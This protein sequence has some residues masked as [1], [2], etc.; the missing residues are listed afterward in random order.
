[1]PRP[2]P[3]PVDYLPRLLSKWGHC[4]RREAE[5]LVV[6]G[7]VTVNGVVKRRVLDE[8]HPSRDKIEV[9]GRRIGP[10]AYLYLKMHKPI[11]VVTTMKDPEGRPTIRDLLPPELAGAM[12]VGRLDQDS[13]GLLLL[14][15]D[16]A[17]G[18]R[19]TGP[20]H[21]VKKVYVVEVDGRPDDEAFAPIRAGL[22]LDGERCRP[23]EV[24]VLERRASSTV[25]QFVLDEGKNRQIRRSLEAIG[26]RVIALHRTRIGPIEL[27]NLAEGTVAPLASEELAALRAA[28]GRSAPRA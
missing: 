10:A 8:V 26:L 27:G 12:P 21:H 13:T 18:D 24:E 23:A 7:R 17:L 9:D 5:R 1:M 14:T 15:N 28:V 19:I 3:R 22:S 11:G 16:H 25:L 2:R 6:A 4:S 20:E